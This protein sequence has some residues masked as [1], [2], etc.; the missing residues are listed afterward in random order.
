MVDIVPGLSGVCCRWS[1]TR[2]RSTG[3]RGQRLS[4][5][6]II[7]SLLVSAF[8]DCFPGVGSTGTIQVMVDLGV[9][10]SFEERMLPR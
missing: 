6:A 2:L 10:V 8:K 5:Q 4:R 7:F 1:M 9:D 3:W